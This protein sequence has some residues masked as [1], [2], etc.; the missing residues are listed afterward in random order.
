VSLAGTG[1]SR[2]HNATASSG[3]MPQPYDIVAFLAFIVQEIARRKPM[4]KETGF[5]AP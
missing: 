2:G 3:L 1:K 5:A 4:L